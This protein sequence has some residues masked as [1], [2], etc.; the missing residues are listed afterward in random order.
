MPGRPT[1][2]VAG[3][4]STAQGE[5]NGPQR[6]SQP[7]ADGARPPLPSPAPS[8]PLVHLCS[9]LPSICPLPSSL[10][11]FLFPSP[12]PQGRLGVCGEGVHR[13]QALGGLP[14]PLTGWQGVSSR[15]PGPWSCD[16]TKCGGASVFSPHPTSWALPKQLLCAPP[17]FHHALPFH[18]P[19]LRPWWVGHCPLL[20]TLTHKLAA[21]SRHCLVAWFV[22]HTAVGIQ[23]QGPA[24]GAQRREKPA[25][26]APPSYLNQPRYAH[27]SQPSFSRLTFNHSSD[28]FFTPGPSR[29]EAQPRGGK[30]WRH[31]PSPL[32]G[33]RGPRLSC[34]SRPLRARLTPPPRSPGP[35]IIDEPRSPWAQPWVSGTMMLKASW[36]AL[37]ASPSGVI[38]VIQ[39]FP[40]PILAATLT[41]YNSSLDVS[42][43]TQAFSI[44]QLEG[45]PSPCTC[46]L[47]SLRKRP[48]SPGSRP[49]SGREGAGDSRRR[50][51]HPAC[52]R[53][54]PPSRSPGHQSSASTHCLE[55]A[56]L[57]HRSY[58][59][60][61]ERLLETRLP[62]PEGRGAV[63]WLLVS[64]LRLLGKHW[65]RAGRG[66]QKL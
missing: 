60:S 64:E 10:L 30:A 8:R 7:L 15:P 49:G 22:Q 21:R 34:Q 18:A 9:L 3:M 58:S 41:P 26:G 52:A 24:L 19:A 2:F 12:N 23:A 54:W 6:P 59:D 20:C 62:D 1:P 61:Q 11:C 25:P 47:L 45:A 56:T 63:G 16:A 27:I 31:L 14:P 55:T 28:F 48:T 29:G 50:A 44:C 65:P 46:F 32:P 39:G 36:E 42:R 35:C 66:S 43:S 37:L 4:G 33:D 40:S 53:T 13:R 51:A 5:G 17:L 38:N 57:T